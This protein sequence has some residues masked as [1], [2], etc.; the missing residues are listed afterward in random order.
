MR[1]L[2]AT[3]LFAAALAAGGFPALA[4]DHMSHGC[5]PGQT[6]TTGAITVS[7]AFTRATLP[8][9]PVGAGFFDIENTGEAADR[10]VGATGDISATI[11]IHTMSMVDGVMKMKHLPEGIEIPAGE[12][13]SLAPGGYHLMIIGP[14]QPFLEGEC[15]ALT[16]AF[17][18]A[19]ALPVQLLVGPIG[20]REAPSGHDGH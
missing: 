9:A 15:V 13:V 8:S 16:L 2:F 1:T 17:E 19:G 6:F 7:G 14:K 3:A 12:T 18:T 20:A 11:E 5:A 4:D 10:L